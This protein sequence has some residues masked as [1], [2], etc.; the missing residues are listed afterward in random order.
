MKK[1]LGFLFALVIGIGLTYTGYNEWQDSKKLVAHG[2]STVGQVTDHYTHKARRS[3]R[4]YYL[5]VAFETEAQQAQKHT[6]RVSSDVYSTANASGTVQVHYLASDPSVVQA[7]PKAETKYASV[8]LGLLFLGFSLGTV[9]FYVG[10]ALVH[11]GRA[12]TAAQMPA[13]INT[14]NQPPASNDAQ[15]QQKAA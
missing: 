7:G 3:G 14:L 4:K 11:R 13:E 9:A 10:V 1:V 15:E 8:V 12:T 2:K 5:V 6:V